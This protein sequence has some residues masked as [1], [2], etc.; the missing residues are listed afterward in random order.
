MNRVVGLKIIGDKMSG[1]AH[2]I[3]N[4]KSSAMYKPAKG[5]KVACNLPP[6][7]V[8]NLY[9]SVIVDFKMMKAIHEGS[10]TVPGDW[11]L[12]ARPKKWMEMQ[13]QF[14]MKHS[15]QVKEFYLT[16]PKY[17]PT[18]TDFNCGHMATHWVANKLQR[19]EIHMYGFDSI[20][21]F[22]TT[23]SS[24]LFLP[25]PRDSLSTE[26]LTTRWRPIW[27]GIFNEFKDTKFVLYNIQGKGSQI[28]L[29]KNC[30]IVSKK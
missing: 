4:G 11:V 16:L 8:E 9:T 23:S 21:A 29:P 5:L 12:G 20:F 30:E 19:N 13:P 22:D 15:H 10:V 14:Y 25:S 18:Y 26:R 27:L 28:K 7:A 6:F 17:A 1:V 2:I 24:D 3:G